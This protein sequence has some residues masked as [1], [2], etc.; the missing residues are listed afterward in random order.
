MQEFYQIG[1]YND[2]RNF[3]W[4]VTCVSLVL[5]PVSGFCTD[6]EIHHTRPEGEPE[7]LGDQETADT[8]REPTY[9]APRGSAQK[10]ESNLPHK[11]P[12]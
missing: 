12:K 6:P 7:R 2:M 9:S 5:V 3:L 1:K 11:A 4:L 10:Q 8:P